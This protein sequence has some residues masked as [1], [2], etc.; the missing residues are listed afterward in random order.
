MSRLSGLWVVLGVAITV[1]HPGRA[2]S[3]LWSDNVNFGSGANTSGDIRRANLDGSNARVLVSGLT[4]PNQVAA[5]PVGG[6]IYWVDGNQDTSLPVGDVRRANLDGSNPQTIVPNQIF[7]IGLAVDG[8]GGN[9]YWR[10]HAKQTD[11]YG[12][13]FLRSNLDGSNPQV[14]F[15]LNVEYG[16]GQMALDTAGRKIYFSDYNDGKIERANLDGTG[17]TSLISGLGGPVGIALD[18]PDGKIY[19]ADNSNNGIYQANLDGTARK[20]ILIANGPDGIALDLDAGK[21]YWTDYGT[22]GK[23]D[24]DIRVANLDGSNPKILV[25]GLNGPIGLTLV[26]LLGDANRDGKVDFSDLLVL[27]QHYGTPTGASRS[28]GDFNGDGT[29]NFGDLLLL[30]QHYGS[31]DAAPAAGS[32]PEPSALVP[33]GAGAA[34]VLWRRRQAAPGAHVNRPV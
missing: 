17:V 8:A 25:T 7:P 2:D 28:D 32:V 33:G 31:T 21:I 22:N 10:A 6:M 15:K 3:L 14:L 24:G 20:R 12:E 1:A 5:D 34:F 16:N 9:V 4:G 23:P 18:L 11:P 29:V 26:P 19:W 13:Q 30:A 27:A